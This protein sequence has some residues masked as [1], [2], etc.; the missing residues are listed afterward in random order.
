MLLRP[1]TD[2]EQG[3]YA[4]RMS[5]IIVVNSNAATITQEA[6][7]TAGAEVQIYVKNPNGFLW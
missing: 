2:I 3:T 4:V 5:E 6:V 1:G 7:G